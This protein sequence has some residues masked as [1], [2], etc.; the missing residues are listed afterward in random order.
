MCEC[1][2]C[3]KYITV[4]T[5][6]CFIHQSEDI[7]SAVHFFIAASWLKLKAE[8]FSSEAKY[9]PS[10]RV[11]GQGSGF[12]KDGKCKEVS[13]CPHKDRETDMCVSPHVDDV[14][15]CAA[16]PVLVQH[17]VTVSSIEPTHLTLIQQNLLRAS[18]TPHQYTHDTDIQLTVSYT[19]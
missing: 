10:F 17:D 4:R 19:H 6:K 1:V 13:V 2:C 9:E 12:I 7:L 11:R 8:G 15:F 14:S 16:V 5:G 18:H 3:C